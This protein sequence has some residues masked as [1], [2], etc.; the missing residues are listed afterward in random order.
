MSTE[1]T[2]PPA[3]SALQV[4]LHT[5]HR[6]L[7]AS[8][9]VLALG[10]L[11]LG[12]YTLWHGATPYERTENA[13]VKG[14]LTYVATKVSGYIQTV[15]T[16]NNRKVEA[17]QQLVSID[18][19]DYEAA[20]ADAESAVALA[21]ATLEQIGAQQTLQATQIRIAQA[22]VTSARAQAA[23]TLADFRR[24]QSL[25]QQGGVSRALYDQASAEQVRA[26]S[27]LNQNEA[28]A[29]Y[30][31]QQLTV[32]RAQ[33]EAAQ[34]SRD[35]ALARLEK[36]RNDLAATRVIAP[37]EGRIAGRNVR[38][39]EYVAVGTRLMAVA[40]TRDLWVE[41]NLKETQ[42]ARIRPGDRVSVRVD[43]VP[44]AR[45][46]ATVESVAGASGSEFAVIPPDNATGNFTKI[47]RRFTVRIV[48]DP[49]QPGLDRLGTGM[50]AVP[51]IAIDSGPGA[52]ASWN[53]LR[54]FYPG[55][56]C[57]TKEQS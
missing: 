42:L 13:Y 8:A 17:G 16:E 31:Q 50:S 29:E 38:P 37:R 21:D 18:P 34:A 4:I 36:T 23:R 27:T 32:L 51:T 35:S 53:P 22:T 44:H 33:R 2:L 7:V 3:P 14:D 25:V 28:Q 20:V 56:T 15:D 54:L 49:D 52:Q 39:G 40:P 46:C 9:I 26:A 12:A 47:V 55:F 48:L 19:K 41:A 24:A 57:A 11:V 30:A 5:S 1:T 10:G 45:Y 43:A 6:V